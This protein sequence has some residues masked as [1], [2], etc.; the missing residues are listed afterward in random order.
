MLIR[1]QW[2]PSAEEGSNNVQK[3]KGSWLSVIT[4]I[5]ALFLLLGLL[6]WTGTYLRN[7]ALNEYGQGYSYQQQGNVVILDLGDEINVELHFGKSSVKIVDAYRV[8]TKNEQTQIILFIQSYLQSQDKSLSR[9]ITDYVG[10]YRLHCK[11]YQCGYEVARTK[12]VDLE[13]ERDPRWYVNVCS[14]LLGWTGL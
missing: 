13:Y 1:Q 2:Y 12:D 5:N 7:K 11:L 4:L 3:R 14:R 10:E 9:M 6:C 8:S